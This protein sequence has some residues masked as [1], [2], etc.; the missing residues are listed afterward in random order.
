MGLAEE[1][2]G[3][4]IRKVRTKKQGGEEEG[5]VGGECGIVVGIAVGLGPGLAVIVVEISV[6]R[7]RLTLLLGNVYIFWTESLIVVCSGMA[8][9]DAAADVGFAGGGRAAERPFVDLM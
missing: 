6:G 1:E 9:T 2:R 8:V 7:A 3:H 5:E 4:C